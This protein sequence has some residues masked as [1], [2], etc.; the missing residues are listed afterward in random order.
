MTATLDLLLGARTRIE[1]GRY[2]SP[3]YLPEERQGGYMMSDLFVQLKSERS[4]SLTAYVNN[5]ENK[6]VYAGASLRPV[7][8]VVFN[9]LRPP[10]TYGLRAAI[11]F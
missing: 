9:I 11:E 3:E 8:P 2:L 5:V 7:F 4:W 10:R 1:S 6:S